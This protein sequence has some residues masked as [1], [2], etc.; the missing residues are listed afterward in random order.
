MRNI[1]SRPRS[2]LYTGL[3]LSAFTLSASATDKALLDILLGNGLIT[4]DQYEA[5]VQQEE[6]TTEQV[7][8]SVAVAEPQSGAASAGEAREME[9]AQVTALDENVQRAIDEAV[10][11]AIEAE[12]PVMASYGSKGFRF[13]SRDGN[14]Q[15]NLQ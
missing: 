5:L 8:S 6:I 14:W 12:S 7:L 3:L 9:L 10:A 15:T 1:P 2:A 4:Q 11:S 13:E